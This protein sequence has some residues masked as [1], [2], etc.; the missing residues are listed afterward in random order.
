MRHARRDVEADV[1]A[2]HS[3]GV[4]VAHPGPR[5]DRR[6]YPRRRGSAPPEGLA[7]RPVSEAFGRRE[8]P[9]NATIPA[10][11]LIERGAHMERHHRPL[12]EADQHR[13]RR[14]DSRSRASQIDQKLTSTGAAIGSPTSRA[15]SRRSKSMG[16]HS[17]PGPPLPQGR[18]RIR[19]HGEQHVRPGWPH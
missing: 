13:L 1:E 18:R 16:N 10:S 4:A 5:T 11:G 3:V 15:G 7:K 14:P 9:E 2:R 6:H 12:A 19:R 17:K 8:A